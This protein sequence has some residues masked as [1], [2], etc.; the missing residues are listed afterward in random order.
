MTDP[1]PNKTIEVMVVL[2]PNQIRAIYEAGPQEWS[3]TKR[4]ITWNLSGRKLPAYRAARLKADREGLTVV[5]DDP[6]VPT[7]RIEAK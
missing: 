1:K 7:F 3:F 2:T 4:L 6:D 5:P